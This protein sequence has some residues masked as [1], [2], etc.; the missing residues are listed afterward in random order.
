[1]DTFGKDLLNRLLDKYENTK[2]SKGNRSRIRITT[3]DKVFE[4]YIGIDSYKY[5]DCYNDTMLELCSNHFIDIECEYETIKAV[6]LNVENVNMVYE[7]LGRDNPDDELSKISD[8]LN[9]YSFDNF[10][11]DFIN[12]VKN[13]IYNKLDYPKIYFSDSKQLEILLNTFIKL[14][15]LDEDINKRDFS[16]KYLGDSKLFES[17]ENKIIK[18]IRDFDSNEYLSD[19]DILASYNI[20]KNTSYAMIKNQLVFKLN[21]CLIDLNKLNF[22]YL[23]SDKMIKNLEIVKT[24]ITKVITIENLTSFYAYNDK[25][26]LIIYLAGFHNHTKQELL[27]KIYFTYPDAKYYHFGDIDAGGFWIYQNLK[28][29]TNIPFIPYKMSVH[30]L[31]SNKNNLKKLTKNDKIRLF[32][33]KDDQ[34][35]II[36]KDEINYMLENDVKLEQEILD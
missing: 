28:E 10:V 26:A 20:V 35:F 27:K 31:E 36:F 22:E 12:F 7:Y 5:V 25:D 1:M 2:R 15:E 23:L 24:K 33:M 19:N 14:F 13:Y 32:K 18:I 4:K 29:K 3:K 34:R 9:K 16:A 17:I 11:D 21:D 30:E 8:I 6:T